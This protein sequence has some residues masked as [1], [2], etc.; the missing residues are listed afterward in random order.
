MKKELASAIA[1]EINNPLMIISGSAQLALME[2]INN[3]TVE[4]N[5]K[6]ILEQ[7]SRIKDIIQKLLLSKQEETGNGI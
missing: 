1:H 3:K 5:L 7:C 2:E 4:E 6:V